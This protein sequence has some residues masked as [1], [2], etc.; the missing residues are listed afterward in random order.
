MK[1]LLGTCTV[2]AVAT[3]LRACIFAADA[4]LKVLAEEKL[5][6]FADRVQTRIIQGKQ[7]TVSGSHTKNLQD[8]CDSFLHT[9]EDTFQALLNHSGGSWHAVFSRTKCVQQP[10]KAPASA[11]LADKFDVQQLA[12]RGTA[13]RN[14]RVQT[15]DAQS[16]KIAKKMGAFV[17]MLSEHMPYEC[18]PVTHFDW[19]AQNLFNL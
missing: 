1:S 2:A 19:V 13:A 11:G 15:S 12:D 9:H 10:V 8:E 14:T 6:H 4:V 17:D 3:V 18:A 7:A 16:K 5:E